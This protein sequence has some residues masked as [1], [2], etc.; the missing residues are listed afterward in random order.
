MLL[1]QL[2]FYQKDPILIARL[3]CRL[4]EGHLVLQANYAHCKD[5]SNDGHRALQE[6]GSGAF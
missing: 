2:V 6:F 3:N 1:M 4:I 5:R